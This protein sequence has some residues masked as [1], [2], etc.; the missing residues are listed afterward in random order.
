MNGDPDACALSYNTGLR[1]L[2]Q[3]V[4]TI[5]ETRDRAGKLLSAA[6]FAVS[7][8]LVALQNYRAELNSIDMLGYIGAGLAIA[9]FRLLRPW[10]SGDRPVSD[11]FMIHVS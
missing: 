4:S 6:T 10:P 9:G 11:S 8:Y 3:Q 2:D 1:T 7:L 5:K